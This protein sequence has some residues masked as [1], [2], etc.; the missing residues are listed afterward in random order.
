MMIPLPFAKWAAVV[1]IAAV[2]VASVCD[3]AANI[4][5]LLP[6]AVSSKLAMAPGRQLASVGQILAMAQSADPAVIAREMDIAQSALRATPLRHAAMRNLGLALARAGDQRRARTTMEQATLISRRDEGALYWLFVALARDRN[7]K[8]AMHSLDLA[9]RTS[10]KLQDVVFPIISQAM[11]RPEFRSVFLSYLR[12]P[13]P[14]L[15]RYLFVGAELPEGAESIAKAVVEVGGLPDGPDFREVERR[16]LERLVL[17]KSYEQARDLFTVTRGRDDAVLTSAAISGPPTDPHYGGLAW[18]FSE[19][20]VASGALV[21]QNGKSA[22]SVLVDADNKSEIATKL[23]FLKVGIYRMSANLEPVAG[24]YQAQVTLR[25]ICTSTAESASNLP[26]SQA[27]ASTTFAIRRNCPTQLLTV[28]A[29][30]EDG[31]GDSEAVISAIALE[32]A[33]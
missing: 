29:S 14:W 23:L 9:L 11:A 27:G 8:A 32:P 21:K 19:S 33:R 1:A 24:L 7:D 13:P 15:I 18:Q 16:L 12:K 28:Y 2:G 31:A 30:G 17:L 22:M 25:L 20:P 4:T 5:L 6:P 3:A 10:T 26:L